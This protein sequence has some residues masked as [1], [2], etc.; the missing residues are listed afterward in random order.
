[1]ETKKFLTTYLP[2]III[3][4]IVILLLFIYSE[5]E[6]SPKQ[7]YCL[8]N[9]VDLT[10]KHYL[11]THIIPIAIYLFSIIVELFFYRKK[12]IGKNLHIVISIL[13][14]FLRFGVCIAL[15]CLATLACL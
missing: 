9:T 15:Y 7:Y 1:M 12:F 2:Y 14:L 13:S 4:N 5:F 6:I 11:V 8:S 3:F 10:I